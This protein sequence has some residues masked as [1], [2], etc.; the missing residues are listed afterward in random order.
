[1]IGWVAFWIALAVVFLLV[2]AYAR[3]GHALPFGLAAGVAAVTCVIELPVAT[4]WGVYAVAALAFHFV[5]RL[6]FLR[7]LRVLRVR[8]RR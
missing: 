3:T 1:M 5:G 4:Q 6:L 8:R 2:E 7:L